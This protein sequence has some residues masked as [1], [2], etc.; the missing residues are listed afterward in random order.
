MAIKIEISK[1]LATFPVAGFVDTIDLPLSYR[2]RR[3]GHFVEKFVTQ[4]KFTTVS[5]SYPQQQL[6]RSISWDKYKCTLIVHEGQNVEN[7]DIAGGVTITTDDGSEHTA[8]IIDFGEPVNIAGTDH[9]QIDFTYYDTNLT[10][11]LAAPVNDF[12]SHSILTSLYSSSILNTLEVGA[13]TY[14]TA[15]NHKVKMPE[16]EQTADKVNGIESVIKSNYQAAISIRLYVNEAQAA[17]LATYCPLLGQTGVA[18]ITYTDKANTTE[19]DAIERIVPKIT[20]VDHDLFQVDIELKHT[21]T[22]VNHF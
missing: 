16:L 6:I 11:Y 4:E 18:A 8:N 15:L 5:K 22:T 13:L 19:Y 9:R 10:N 12:L 21:N 1:L 3:I 20:E 7:I 2:P 17:Y 14:Y